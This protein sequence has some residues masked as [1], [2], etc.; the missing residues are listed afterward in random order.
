MLG[1]S[2]QQTRV[3]GRTTNSR[4][5]SQQKIPFMNF[6]VVNNFITSCNG[7][8]RNRSEL[9]HDAVDLEGAAAGVL[10]DLAPPHLL[11]HLH[12]L[13]MLS[14]R[15]RTRSTRAR[16]CHITHSALSTSPRRAPPPCPASLG[17]AACGRRIRS[18][19]FM[20]CRVSRSRPPP[21]H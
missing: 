10:E 5:L 16:A 17:G 1:G 2:L 14:L 4:S 20:P 15:T 12:R 6:F 11:P 9:M 3:C 8:G 13:A 18:A 21:W 19:R 7:V